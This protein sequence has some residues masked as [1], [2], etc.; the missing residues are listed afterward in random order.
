MILRNISK[1]EY[2]KYL[3]TKEDI[4]F[5][6]SPHALNKLLD[7]GF[8]LAFFK[9]Y[10]DE[11]VVAVGAVATVHLLKFFKYAYAPNGFFIDYRDRKLMIEFT[12]ALKKYLKKKRVIY[13][14]INPYIPAKERNRDG[15]VIETGFDNTDIIDNLIACGYKLCDDSYDVDK[16]QPRWMSVLDLRKKSDSDVFEEFSPKT[17]NDIRSTAK[18]GVKVRK[19]GNDEFGL[20]VKLGDDAGK[21]HDFKAKSLS[22]YQNMAKHYGN[23]LEVYYAYLDLETYERSVKVEKEKIETEV[24]DLA[25]FIEANP[26]AVKKQRRLKAANEYLDGLKRKEADLIKMRSEHKKEVPLAAAMFIKYKKEVVYLFSG[27]DYRY[28]MYR[29]S[30]AIQWQVIKEAIRDGYDFYNMYGISGK[31]KK[32]E[33]GYGVF[34]FKRGFNCR[35]VELIGDFDLVLHPFLYKIAKLRQ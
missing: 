28:H 32:D 1:D 17:R 15:E 12:R 33:E 9:A 35:V 14:N 29:G 21:R 4:S 31:F 3:D 16:P 10:K 27:S 20:L 22:Y 11:K 2:Y 24:S 8:E 34:D 25:T 6:R 5:I 30:Y 23:N 26:Q 13:L 18:F 7:D 19:L